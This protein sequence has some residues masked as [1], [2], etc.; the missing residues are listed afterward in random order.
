MKCKFTV[1]YRTTWFIL[2]KLYGSCL[3]NVKHNGKLCTI[4]LKS[5]TELYWWN[6]WQKCNCCSSL[7]DFSFSKGLKAK[8][9]SWLAIKQ[10]FPIFKKQPQTWLSFLVPTFII[11]K[12]EI[13]YC[14]SSKPKYPVREDFNLSDYLQLL[15]NTDQHPKQNGQFSKVRKR[16]IWTET[17]K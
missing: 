7:W 13:Q 1:R 15:S 14:L 12:S 8:K 3:R 4:F 9:P 17:A 2:K 10:N 16:N 6:W 11:L 5:T